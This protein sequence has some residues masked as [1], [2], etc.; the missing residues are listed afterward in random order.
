MPQHQ[1]Y[2]RYFIQNFQEECKHVCRVYHERSLRRSNFS[3]KILQALGLGAN[4]PGVD[5]VSMGIKLTTG[6]VSRIGALAYDTYEIQ[7]LEKLALAIMDVWDHLEPIA[8]A[9]AHSA[10]YQHEYAITKLIAKNSLERFADNGVKR[11]F[12]YLIR[13]Q[14]P[15]EQKH[16]LKGLVKGRSGAGVEGFLNSRLTAQQSDLTLYA[17][18]LYGRA[19]AR[20]SD[21]LW[22][23]STVLREKDE[24]TAGYFW[25]SAEF[26]K[27]LG[28]G[29]IQPKIFTEE[30]NH[31]KNIARNVNESD[32]SDYMQARKRGYWGSFNQFIGGAI[33]RF[34]GKLVNA[35]LTG[36][37]FSEVDFANAEFENCC[38]DHCNFTNAILV[39]TKFSGK[40]TAKWTRFHNALM[41]KANMR[42]INFDYADFEH[43]DTSLADFTSATI[44]HTH[45]QLSVHAVAT[46]V[47]KGGEYPVEETFLPYRESFGKVE[48]QFVKALSDYR[49]RPSTANQIIYQNALKE[50]LGTLFK[51]L[52]VPPS[53]VFLIVGF[54]DTL[55]CRV[56][57]A[58]STTDDAALAA[59]WKQFTEKLQAFNE[60]HR[61]LIKVEK[62]PTQDKSNLVA[63]KTE[64]FLPYYLGGD[65]Q[66]YTESIDILRA[67]QT[68]NFR[69]L[70]HQIAVW[71]DAASTSNT[72]PTNPSPS[73]RAQR[74]N[75]GS[76]HDVA[77]KPGLL[78]CA[79]NDGEGDNN[80][81]DLG[82][83]S[84]YLTLNQDDQK[85]VMRQLSAY[86]SELFTVLANTPASDGW[87]YQIDHHRA[88]WRSQLFALT[89]ENPQQ[90]SNAITW[91]TRD[92]KN[93]DN[94]EV[95]TYKLRKELITQLLTPEGEFKEK[96]QQAGRHWVL[97]IRDQQNNIIAW[98]K[99][100][101]ES[102]GEELA[103][104]SLM[105]QALGSN[106]CPETLIVK[107]HVPQ[108]PPGKQNIAIQL[109]EHLP[110]ETFDS[111]N[112]WKSRETKPFRYD[113][114][115]AS[116]VF[117]FI[118]LPGDAHAHN[119]LVEEQ[120]DALFIRQFDLERILFPAQNEAGHNV[121]CFAWGLDE[122]QTPWPLDDEYLKPILQRFLSLDIYALLTRWIA[123]LKAEHA[124]YQKLF[125][126]EEFKQH[127]SA[128]NTLFTTNELA[129]MTMP[130]SS[131][132]PF[133]N[134]TI[135]HSFLTLPLGTDWLYEIAKRL[136]LIQ[137]Q[138]Q[139][140]LATKTPITTLTLLK[141]L[142]PTHHT[143]YQSGFTDVQAGQPLTWLN[144]PIAWSHLKQCAAALFNTEPNFIPN[145]ALPW[146]RFHYLS[147]GSYQITA[148]GN[149]VSM[150]GNKTLMLSK[151]LQLPD[152]FSPEM[153]LQIRKGTELSPNQ[154]DDRL[155]QL[156]RRSGLSIINALL[157]PQQN[158]LPGQKSELL[159][160]FYRLPHRVRMELMKLILS[161]IEIEKAKGS[162]FVNR[163]IK[164]MKA[165]PYTELDLSPFADVLTDAILLEFLTSD[166]AG[167]HLTKLNL[168]NCKK[169]THASVNALA[170]HVP[171]LMYLDLSGTGMTQIIREAPVVFQSLQHLNVSNSKTLTR[172]NLYAPQLEILNAKNCT[173]LIYLEVKSK[174]DAIVE[175]SGCDALDGKSIKGCL[176][177]PYSTMNKFHLTPQEVRALM[178][179]SANRELLNL[180]GNDIYNE[181]VLYLA[182][183]FKVN[184]SLTFIALN[185]N[186]I[187]DVGAG[188]LADAL[189][190]NYTLGWIDLGHNLIGDVGAGYLAK[191]LKVNRT[192]SSIWLDQNNI[193]VT[194]FKHLAEALKLNKTLTL[195]DLRSNYRIG[196]GI[197]Y[198]AEA[199]M[200]NYTLTE[201]RVHETGTLL[202]ESSVQKIKFLLQRNQT[203]AERLITAVQTHQL[204]QVQSLI[205][206]GVQPSGDY[207]QEKLGK[208]TL[209]HE[210]VK[211][212]NVAILYALLQHPGI[213]K[214]RKN[215]QAIT[216][217]QLAEQLGYLDCVAVLQGKAIP[218]LETKASSSM[219]LA[220]VTH[221]AASQMQTTKE[222][223]NT[224]LP[225]GISTDNNTLTVDFTLADF[226]HISHIHELLNEQLA[227][228]MRYEGE[229]SMTLS[230]DNDAR[231]QTFIQ[232]LSAMK[233]SG[234]NALTFQ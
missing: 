123:H 74:S 218:L 211:H 95:V 50:V 121:Q 63:Q 152:N 146:L 65:L 85:H 120:K 48:S 158:I 200:V 116:W 149:S 118:F 17:E 216:A 1:F 162:E 220:P 160:R 215:A 170:N 128:S 207:L 7:K 134:K 67:N 105:Q 26:V 27:E 190:V 172:I 39:S 233:T 157:D 214:N 159:E 129:K 101:P 208:A 124:F 49:G 33:A 37:N 59:L 21:G 143:R 225:A 91:Q 20:T 145:V 151:S 47:K 10:A 38:L 97:P 188:Y 108:R 213:Q 166:Y 60:K 61:T 187:R 46:N 165:I 168:A 80:I 15:F 25:A 192:L 35:D 131:W 71:L 104:V 171:H 228:A 217:L 147:R 5:P 209:L 36:G 84:L 138:I 19:A 58:E 4:M 227:H 155:Q 234:A 231:M 52:D 106:Y 109:S 88:Q 194:G 6:G 66:L 130:E 94:A 54:G 86:P 44:T 119:Y 224:T 122:S 153:A 221:L 150:Q 136:S 99:I 111:A 176:Y 30:L 93:A 77:S 137:N 55:Q 56:L 89:E 182:V 195:I 174:S 198:L 154:A 132:S 191:A 107:L 205:T 186:Y 42:G 79:R 83:Q 112:T 178:S 156:E 189:N 133:A 22:A 148:T 12:E 126:E 181:D 69:K 51:S 196:E 62:L 219:T 125:T 163:I 141:Q 164:L 179:N 212:R 197:E 9:T 103:A 16:F 43:A 115:F 180:T 73:L 23:N 76:E 226:R 113:S 230:F 210:A 40:T 142:H 31:Y 177:F 3:D 206:R 102:P 183:I 41:F 144:F 117:G 184:H 90:D 81:D 223:N 100:L 29:P 53:L 78:R 82:I 45:C 34:S 32:F 72:Q 222:E 18:D 28:F 199:L 204:E 229:T 169:L 57:N 13:E 127:Y 8:R 202:Y 139:T 75:P 14:H 11:L 114:L 98:A 193:G 68:E 24:P 96:P 167:E 2:I 185:E 203:L 201:V 173:Q 92:L 64:L 70:Q 140:H 87:H 110:G 232:S 161:N 175:L 135:D